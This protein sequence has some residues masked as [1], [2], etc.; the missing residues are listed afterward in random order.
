MDAAAPEPVPPQPGPRA[1]R[2]RL[3]FDPTATVVL[4]VVFTVTGYAYTLRGAHPALVALYASGAAD[5]LALLFLTV[6]ADAGT[7]PSASRPDPDWRAS[8]TA[9]PPPPPPTPTPSSRPSLVRTRARREAVRLGAS[10]PPGWSV[11]PWGQAQRQRPRAGANGAPAEA[12]G[13]GGGD[14]LVE[15]YCMTCHIWCPARASHCGVCGFCR[16]RFDR[17]FPFIGNCVARDNHAF[18]RGFCWRRRCHP[19]YW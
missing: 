12:A 4:T 11:D 13:V 18:S 8:P 7:L 16:D 2:S 6:T 15:K 10:L 14:A 17:H 19:A 1:P 9:P 5:T 3:S